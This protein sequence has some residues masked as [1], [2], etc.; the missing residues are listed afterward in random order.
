[1][2]T[3]SPLEINPHQEERHNGHTQHGPPEPGE[4]LRAY[5]DLL[6]GVRQGA[7]EA[8]TPEQWPKTPARSDL[9]RPL[10]GDLAQEETVGLDDRELWPRWLTSSAW[11]WRDRRR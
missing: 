5:P 10:I 4:S 8:P 1:M 3:V 6:R 7:A 9:D 11:R 2:A